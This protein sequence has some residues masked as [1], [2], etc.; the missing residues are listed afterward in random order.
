MIYIAEYGYTAYSLP[1]GVV[2]EVPRFPIVEVHGKTWA[3]C[4]NMWQGVANINLSLLNI[5]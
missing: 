2:A 3:T 5:Q 4:G 1:D